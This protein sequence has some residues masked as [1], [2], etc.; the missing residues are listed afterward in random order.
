MTDFLH[1][2]ADHKIYGS[3]IV[4]TKG[5]IV[6][7]K[8]ARAYLGIKAGDTLLVT[9]K[10]TCFLGFVKADNIKE[11]INKL[12]KSIDIEDTSDKKKQHRKS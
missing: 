2:M 1:A 6:I 10:G 4:N 8:E 11:L 5:Q 12:Q 7:P 9:S 3:V